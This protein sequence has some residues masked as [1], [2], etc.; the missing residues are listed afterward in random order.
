MNKRTLIIGGVA[1]VLAVY[2]INRL[3]AAN[4]VGAKVQYRLEGTPQFKLTGDGL[5]IT[6]NVTL[7]N[8]TT[9]STSIKQPTFYIYKSTKPNEYTQVS[10]TAPSDKDIEI[11]ANGSAKLDPINFLITW[12]GV[13]VIGAAGVKLLIQQLEKWKVGNEEIYKKLQSYLKVQLYMNY[14]TYAA[15]VR[16]E[17]PMQLIF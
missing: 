17:S 15:G 9:S 14:I 4:T 1:S 6:I 7:L 10:Q 16:Y 3:L 5:G 8:D 2:G 11:P 12:S 13:G